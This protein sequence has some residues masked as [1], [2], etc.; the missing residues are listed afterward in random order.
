MRLK[1]D[2]YCES[3]LADGKEIYAEDGDVFDLIATEHGDILLSE[4]PVGIQVHLCDRVIGSPR[5]LF[6]RHPHT[7]FANSAEHG[8][9][10]HM[11]TPFFPPTDESN[12]EILT[13]Y[14]KRVIATGER[15]LAPLR[16]ANRIFFEESTIYDD[17][18]YLSYGLTVHDQTLLEAESFAEEINSRVEGAYQPPSLFLC[19]AS[20]D[21]LFVDK[22]ALELDRRALFAWY[23][24]RE[25][26]VGDSIV[27]KVN[28][29]L[30]SSAF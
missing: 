28:S 25:I 27:E 30:E 29:G 8:L 4:I 2:E 3:L 17:I 7:T 18:A 24:K 21:K 13:E 9:V 1:T 15:S 6:T 20:E 26:F 22:L 14:F 11:S 5:D 10:V 23:D 16:E 19:H 12:G